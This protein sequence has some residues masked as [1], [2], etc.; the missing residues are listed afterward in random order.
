MTESVARRG[1][2]P[3]STVELH[4]TPY[5]YRALDHDREIRLLKLHREPRNPRV[6]D[7]SIIH[8]SLDDSP[9]Y[10]AVSYVWGSSQSTQTIP[11]IDGCALSVT[12]SLAE[13]LPYLTKSCRTG[14][15]WIDQV[16][17]N[18]AS[19]SERNAQV[20]VM[21]EIYRRS[22]RCMIWLNS[23]LTHDTGL[24]IQWN[25]T[26]GTGEAVRRFFRSFLDVDS[27]RLWQQD[28]AEESQTSV[29]ATN[30][31]DQSLQ[32]NMREHLLWFLE[33]AWFN[34][35]WVYQE[36]VLASQTVFLIGDFELSGNEIESAFDLGWLQSAAWLETFGKRLNI[37]SRRASIY[38]ES[39]G[40]KFLLA[41]NQS[42]LLFN[43]FHKSS[44][45]LALGDRFTAYDVLAF[46][47]ILERMG[48][49]QA[50]NDRDHVYA[51]LGLAP[52]LLRHMK[53]DYS[54]TVEETF[55]AMM[56]A[57]VKESGSLDFLCYTRTETDVSRSKLRLP[58]WVPDWTF[59][60]TNVHMLCHDNLFDAVGPG[61]SLPSVTKCRHYDPPSSNWN[62]LVVAGKTLDTVLFKLEPFSLYQVTPSLD[63]NF[64]ESSGCLPW[65][66]ATL[67]MFMAEMAERNYPEGPHISRKALLRT[68]LMDGVY[69]ATITALTSGESPYRIGQK[70]IGLPHYEK[71]KD[72]IS[73]L[74][75]SDR[76]TCD[77]L[78]H[79]ANLQTLHE[80]SKVQYRRRIAC[81]EHGRLAL[82]PDRVQEGDKITLLHGSRVPVILRPRPGG[83][84]I[85]IGQCYYDGAMYG[86]MADPIDENAALFLL[87]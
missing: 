18:Q 38:R 79:A 27:Q 20:K 34:R 65:E 71:I 6:V 86:K 37:N 67:D 68:L 70:T 31:S 30:T 48:A 74:L 11:L 21:G 25:W 39:R 23:D 53:V 36:F 78:P 19:I 12:A 33:H 22:F 35:T 15:L 63:V 75:E 64:A 59:Y 26:H 61:F 50:Q 58:S 47:D 29:N 62:E 57:M 2:I 52:C 49:S 45:N 4:I 73:A 77:D 81:C 3:L 8:V 60:A 83:S 13:A 1:S 43:N 82:A 72:V 7:I 80:L 85:V 46:A 84:Y 69:W 51:F 87:T 76:F 17:I 28:R 10:E 41:A 54:L 40:F 14:Y 24:D 9:T 55:A 44:H 16:T 66:I 56:K 42:R 32:L 5:K